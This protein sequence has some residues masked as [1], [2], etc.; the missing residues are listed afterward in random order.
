M[1]TT[2][3][4]P[5]KKC[6]NPHCENKAALRGLC[7]GCYCS[8]MHLV[9]AKK[10]TWMQLESAGKCLIPKNHKTV[11]KWLLAIKPTPAASTPAAHP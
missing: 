5:K 9:K 8:A 7:K 2:T 1:A 11:S 10:V 6:L 3:P 4:T